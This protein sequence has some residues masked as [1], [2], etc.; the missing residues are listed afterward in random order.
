MHWAPSMRSFITPG[1]AT[2]AG[3]FATEDG[4]PQGCRQHA[5]AIHADGADSEAERL[6]YLSSGLH[7]SGDASLK[8]SRP[9]NTAHGRDNKP[10]RIPS[11]TMSCWPSRLHAAGRMFV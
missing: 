5:R 6:V 2:G 3:V 7:K 11:C 9:A 4:L 1:S 10:T 8:R